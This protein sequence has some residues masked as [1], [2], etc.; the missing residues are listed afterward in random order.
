ML[1][2]FLTRIFGS[3]NERVLRQ[4][5]KTV[6]K[7]NTLEPEFQALSDDELRGKTAQFRERIA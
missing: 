1:N 2:T 6:A 3:R 4:L 5:G 7:I